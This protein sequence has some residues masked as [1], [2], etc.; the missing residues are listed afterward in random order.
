MPYLADLLVKYFWSRNAAEKVSVRVIMLKGR[1]WHNEVALRVY[2]AA[3]LILVRSPLIACAT[4]DRV[5]KTMTIA[6]L[7][8]LMDEKD[9]ASHGA[10]YD[11]SRRFAGSIGPGASSKREPAVAGMR[12]SAVTAT[13]NRHNDGEG[14]DDDE[15]ASKRPQ[16]T[17]EPLQETVTLAEIG[18]GT[19]GNRNIVLYLRVRSAVDLRA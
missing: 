1:C 5:C 19:D 16:I 14:T 4:A 11:G 15:E 18:L 7:R 9:Y 13:A 8:Q 3:S 6:E 17:A 10:F 12:L 2:S